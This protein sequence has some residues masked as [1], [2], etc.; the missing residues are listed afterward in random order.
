VEVWRRPFQQPG[1]ETALWSVFHTGIP[2]LTSTQLTA[3]RRDPVAKSV[4]FGADDP[5]YSKGAPARV[6]ASIG[7]P[8]PVIV[9]GRHLTMI[10]SPQQV[11]AAVGALIA[12][13]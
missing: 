3:L 1:A 6:A 13:A 5:E 2:S 11:A 12:R 7:A 8:P 10:A 9:P 4:V